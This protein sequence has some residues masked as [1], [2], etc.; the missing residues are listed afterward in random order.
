MKAKKLR[1]PVPYME[2]V[3]R[4]GMNL[5]RNLAEKGIDWWPTDEYTALPVYFRRLLEEAPK[6][7][8]FYVVNCRWRRHPGE[9]TSAALG[10]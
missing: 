10:E 5:N 8:D 6:D 2:V 3:K 9:Q 7:H 1:Y 4:S